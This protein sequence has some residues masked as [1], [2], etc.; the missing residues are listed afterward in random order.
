MSRLLLLIIIFNMLIISSCEKDNSTTNLKVAMLADG[1]T[2]DDLN[3]LQSCKEGLERA[4]YDFNLTVEYICDTGA[5]NYLQRIDQIALQNYDLIIAIGYMWDDAV[6]DASGNYPD[7]KFLLVDTELSET[8]SNA[9]SMVFDIDEAAFPIGFLS[10]WWAEYYGES[11]P[12]TACIG[13]LKIPQIRQFIEPFNKGVN[14]YNKSYLKNVDT[15]VVYAGGFLDEELGAFLSDSLINA[16]SDMIFGVG[17]E[18]ESGALLQAKKNN[19]WCVGTDADQYY[20]FPEVSDFI[21]TTAV[22]GLDNSIY[23]VVKSF[24]YNSFD[25]GNTYHG[26]LQ[27]MGVSIAPFHNADELIA[28]SIKAEIENIKLG[29]TNGNISTEW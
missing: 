25:G 11:T 12:K 23:N 26:N 18:T 24:T 14:Y 28:D 2:F 5:N 10:A 6:L 19:I 1:V 3:F 29:I 16:G 17:S 27:N 21:L 15:A 4:K 9:V 13:A 20:A 22:K 7:I 8:R